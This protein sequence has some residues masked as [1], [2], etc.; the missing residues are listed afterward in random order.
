ML[1]SAGF[2]SKSLCYVRESEAEEIADPVRSA[3]V[4]LDPS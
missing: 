4:Q 2:V 1:I 3:A